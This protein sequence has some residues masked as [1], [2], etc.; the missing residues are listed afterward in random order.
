M[1]QDALKT[2]DPDKKV[3]TTIKINTLFNPLSQGSKYQ[4][5][6]EEENMDFFESMLLKTQKEK[7]EQEKEY[8]FKERIIYNN[9]PTEYL[10]KTN[11]DTT[12]T[13][14]YQNFS[15]LKDDFDTSNYLHLTNMRLK[16]LETLFKKNQN[17]GKKEE[18]ENK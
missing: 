12:N 6:L 7:K 16:Y 14:Y 13:Y 10:L 5:S 3:T 9:L 1:S 4:T 18:K 17:I 15:E 11:S 8:N 2:D